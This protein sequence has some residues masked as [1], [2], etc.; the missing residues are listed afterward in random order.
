[1]LRLLAHPPPHLFSFGKHSTFTYKIRFFPF[2]SMWLEQTQ[3]SQRHSDKVTFIELCRAL[4]SIWAFL[5]QKVDNLKSSPTTGREHL[6]H[7][8]ILSLWKEGQ[9]YI[10]INFSAKI[11][12]GKPSPC[13]HSEKKQVAITQTVLAATMPPPTPLANEKI[14]LCAVHMFCLTKH[15]A[16][17]AF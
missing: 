8:P 13:F 11:W 12:A 7:S 16:F 15:K 6:H 10:W 3:S 4:L 1:M 9:A 14:K 2:Y 17:L 5:L